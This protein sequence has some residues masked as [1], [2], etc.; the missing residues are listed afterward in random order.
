MRM[1]FVRDEAG[2]LV[3]GTDYRRSLL[4]L[5]LK[6]TLSEQQNHRCCFCGVRMGYGLGLDVQPTF[7]HVLPRS[8]GGSDSLDNLVIACHRCNT[9]RGYASDLGTPRQ[10]KLITI[11]DRLRT[12]EVF[13]IDNNSV[14]NRERLVRLMRDAQWLAEELRKRGKT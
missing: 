2:V 13:L 7:E 4:A 11:E 5:Y 6:E 9:T 10:S 14:P 8:H 1:T 3:G 12:L